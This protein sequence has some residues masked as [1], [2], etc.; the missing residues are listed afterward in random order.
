MLENPQEYLALTLL[1]SASNAFA[2]IKTTLAF[3]AFFS[4]SAKIL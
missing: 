2:F 4:A 1:K 3:S